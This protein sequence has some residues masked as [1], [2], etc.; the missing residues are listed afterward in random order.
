MIYNVALRYLYKYNSIKISYC[1][2]HKSINV[3]MFPLSCFSSLL[4]SFAI[5][6]N[7]VSISF[8]EAFQII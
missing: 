3:L 1:I 4:S 8:S 6:I 2:F 7:D 5:N